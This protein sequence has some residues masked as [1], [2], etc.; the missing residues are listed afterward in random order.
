MLEVNVLRVMNLSSGVCVMKKRFASFIAAAMILSALLIHPAYGGR[1]E[2]VLEPPDVNSGIPFMSALSRRHSSRSFSSR[3]LP[4]RIL[5]DLF[6]AACGVNRPG[7][8]KRTA[9]SA[10]N[11]QEIDVYA[12]LPEGLYRYDA[13]KHS[14]GLVVEADLRALTGRQEYV[15]GASL[16]LIYVADMS[17]VAGGTREEKLLYAGA[18][19]GFIGQNVYLYCASAGL[20]TVIRGYIDK[21]MLARAMKLRPDHMIVL[22]Q[23]V[24]YPGD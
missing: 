6:W 9:P 19:T 20:A 24:G 17:R 3:A 8:G 10:M 1:T 5:S 13:K 16:N 4:H 15:A 18:D 21:K 2:I 11:R 12:A 7:S 14:L 22:C 23:S